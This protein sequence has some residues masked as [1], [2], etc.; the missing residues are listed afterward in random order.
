MIHIT[1]DVRGANGKPVRVL[2]AERNQTTGP[3]WLVLPGGQRIEVFVTDIDPGNRDSRRKVQLHLTVTAETVVGLADNAD[4]A[5]EIDRM[6]TAIA[7]ATNP[8]PAGRWYTDLG[9]G[10][11]ARWLTGVQPEPAPATLTPATLARWFPAEPGSDVRDER[12]W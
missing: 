8:Q 3:G 4:P 2:F 6:A 11:P 9:D 7:A 12:E 5:P 1:A 10:N